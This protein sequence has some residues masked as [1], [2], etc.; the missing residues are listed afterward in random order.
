MVGKRMQALQYIEGQRAYLQSVLAKVDRLDDYTA[1]VVRFNIHRCFLTFRRYED[2]IANYP[3]RELDVHL[4]HKRRFAYYRLHMLDLG[5]DW[6]DVIAQIEGGRDGGQ[7]VE[8][9]T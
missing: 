2:D 5:I 6:D 4:D 8:K 7:T 9:R 1:K 3:D